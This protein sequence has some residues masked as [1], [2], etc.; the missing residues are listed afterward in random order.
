MH[1][2]MT[3]LLKKKLQKIV[4]LPEKVTKVT[5]TALIH[6]SVY[7]TFSCN[8]NKENIVKLAVTVAL[9]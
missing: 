7:Y 3:V 4:Y 1:F 6:Y 2:Y 9:C 5:E 8:S